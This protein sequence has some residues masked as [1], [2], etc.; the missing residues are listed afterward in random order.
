MGFPSGTFLSWQFAKGSNILEIEVDGS[1]IV[2]EPELLV[3]SALDGIGVLYMVEDYVAPMVSVGRLI[4]GLEEWMPSPS[5]AFFVYYSSR[6][7]NPASLQALIDFL[8]ANLR[9]NAKLRKGKT[10]RMSEE[11]S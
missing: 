2:N 4:P 8:Q 11:A 10:R 9:T 6:R 3:R 5:D 7:Q 1:V